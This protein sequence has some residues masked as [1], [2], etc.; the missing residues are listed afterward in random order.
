MSPLFWPSAFP[1]PIVLSVSLVVR[2]CQLACSVDCNLYQGF[3]LAA[4]HSGP[5]LLHVP[6][7]AFL[8]WAFL[9]D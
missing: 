4:I 7:I 9:P 5:M 8:F 3:S 2:S 1:Y 6:T